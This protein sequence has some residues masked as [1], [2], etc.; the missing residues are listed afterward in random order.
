MGVKLQVDFRMEVSRDKQPGNITYT[1]AQKS[2]LPYQ[3]QF[4]SMLAYLRKH[5]GFN[6][7][8]KSSKQ[9]YPLTYS[10]DSP[11]MNVVFINHITFKSILGY[12]SQKTNNNNVHCKMIHC[13]FPNLCI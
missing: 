1:E 4:L 11:R 2:V 3:N 5:S 12:A 9:V 6:F 8:T 7:L 10:V 13:I